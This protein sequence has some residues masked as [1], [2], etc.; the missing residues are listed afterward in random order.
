MNRAHVGHRRHRVELDDLLRN[1]Q[2][3][4]VGPDLNGHRRCA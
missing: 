1:P 2:K 4:K 3:K